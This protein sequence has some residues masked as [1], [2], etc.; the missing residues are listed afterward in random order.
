MGRLVDGD[1]EGGE[2]LGDIVC[3]V[4]EGN[5]DGSAVGV[6]VGEIDGTVLGRAVGM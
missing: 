6:A 5:P 3:G 4:A 2:S 1:T